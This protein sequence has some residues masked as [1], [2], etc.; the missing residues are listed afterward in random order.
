MIAASSILMSNM[1]S[2]IAI[3]P[4]GCSISI[5]LGTT[6]THSCRYWLV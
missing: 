6:G 1:A 4:G 2:A 3:D 5:I